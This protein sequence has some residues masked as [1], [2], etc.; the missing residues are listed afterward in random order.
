MV[1][2]YT[3]KHE[4][5]HIVGSVTPMHKSVAAVRV[6]L[7][8]RLFAAEYIVSK[9]RATE[10]DVFEIIEYQLRRRIVVHLYLFKNDLSLLD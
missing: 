2:V 6:Y 10:D 3:S 5:Q 8:E 4:K 1:F 9:R 7:R